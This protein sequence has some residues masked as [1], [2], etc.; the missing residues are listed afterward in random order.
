MLT[1]KNFEKFEIP[2]NIEQSNK[3]KDYNRLNSKRKYHNFTIGQSPFPVPKYIVDSLSKHANRGN[4]SPP[5]GKEALSEKIANFYTNLFD[6]KINKNSLF[7]GLGT[8]NVLFMLIGLIEGTYFLP[9]PAWGGYEPFLNFYGR[10]I[11]KIHL[12]VEKDYKYDLEELEIKFKSQKGQKVF[13]LNN[14]H[15]P[16]GKVL[17]QKEL[18]GLVRL[19]KK[20]NVVV[21]SDEIY[22]LTTYGKFYSL[23]NLYPERTFLLGG[24]SKDRGAAGYRFG[25][26][27]LPTE[28]QKQ[29]RDNFRKMISN[30]YISLPTPI[31]CA[32]ETAY[33]ITEELQNYLEKT[34]YVYSYLAEKISKKLSM[35]NGIQF[36]KPESAFYITIDMNAYRS[37]LIKKGIE[38]ASQL[39]DILF[40]DPY[41]VALVPGYTL[42]LEKKDFTFRLAYVDF[43]GNNI[44]EMLSNTKSS[45]Y[46]EKLEDIDTFNNIYTGI[47]KLKLFLESLGD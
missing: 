43:D 35:I 18:E 2:K 37:K 8:K 4:Y 14:P 34:V 29:L 7:Y 27:V 23:Y 20:Y 21:F 45:N 33:E 41:N 13:I 39:L 28:K 12:K 22:G 3:I 47:E 10:D 26:C 25:I 44:L 19:F 6:L 46:Y 30:F 36:K 5:L 15:N 17:S 1:N 42:G 32:A 38:D 40:E 31:Q 24:I 11:E 16:S 9:V